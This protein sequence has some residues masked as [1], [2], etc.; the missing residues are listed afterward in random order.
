MGV[1]A[2]LAFEALFE[3]CDPL[4][5]TFGQQGAG[6]VHDVY[7]VRAVGLHEL[8]LIQE[9]FRPPHMCHHQEAHSLQVHLLC[10]LE[11]LL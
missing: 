8:R 2:N 10:Y 1:E 5:R 9:V 7:A 3:D 6:R 11:V 4:L